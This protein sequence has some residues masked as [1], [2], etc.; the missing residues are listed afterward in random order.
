VRLGDVHEW[1]IAGVVFDAVD[2]R[3]LVGGGQIC[4][5]ALEAEGFLNVFEQSIFS[6]S[7]LFMTISRVLF[8]SS[9]SAKSFRV[10]VSMPADALMTMS[11]VSAAGIA[12][13]AGPVKSG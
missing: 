5:S 1:G 4:A 2:D 13:M 11:A 3:S 7:I 9:A 10:F 12:F 8:A 6:A